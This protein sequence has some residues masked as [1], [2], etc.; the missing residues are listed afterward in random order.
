MIKRYGS[1][2][3]LYLPLFAK[4]NAIR[5][6]KITAETAST[7]SLAVS[8][9]KKSRNDEASH[10][11]QTEKNGVFVSLSVIFTLFHCCYKM[12]LS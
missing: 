3:F 5:K 10:I 8:L 12:I 2:S 11:E 4:R 6:A 1:V 7:V 9:E